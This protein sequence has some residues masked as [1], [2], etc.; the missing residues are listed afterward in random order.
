MK[1]CNGAQLRTGFSNLR[2]YTLTGFISLALSGCMSASCLDASIERS[3][4]T[5]PGENRLEF[6]VGDDIKVKTFTCEEYYDAHC[7]VRGN[8][9]SIRETG[10]QNSGSP[11][12]T[13]F[14]DV[15]GHVLTITTPNC[16]H[17]IT[18]RPLNPSHVFIEIDGRNYFYKGTVNNE[19]VYQLASQHPSEE[20]ATV[21]IKLDIYVNGQ[22]IEWP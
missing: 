1:S 6:H 11:S 3:P 21:S 14:N 4:R 13:T 2:R 15:Q 7:S 10:T 17:I 9:W 12:R 16:R 18:N 8:W 22:S 19:R 20:A 5:I